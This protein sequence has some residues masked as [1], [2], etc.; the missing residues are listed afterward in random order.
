[1][2]SLITKQNALWSLTVICI[3]VGLA[4]LVSYGRIQTALTHQRIELS[5]LKSENYSL[6]LKQSGYIS[7]SHVMEHALSGI[8]FSMKFNS[9]K[10]SI[11]QFFYS[12]L[13]GVNYRVQGEPKKSVMEY[14]EAIQVALKDMENID[15]YW[16]ADA[17]E[18]SAYAY[19]LMGDFNSAA[20]NLSASRLADNGSAFIFEL[21][22][23]IK[24]L[25][26]RDIEPRQIQLALD[27]AERK[28]KASV[29]GTRA[30]KNG[31]PYDLRNMAYFYEDA[32]MRNM[33]ANKKLH[34][35]TES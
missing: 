21:T 7:N 6:N 15:S 23:E 5:R 17:Y 32:E 1:M 28:L 9:S 2:K 27:E 16:L 30:Q 20:A 13:Q 14:N 3:V 4:A 29:S 26:R 22:T 31:R 33:C 24:L 12:Y 25:C 34:F 18:G 10:S 11:R 35:P 19:L 8:T